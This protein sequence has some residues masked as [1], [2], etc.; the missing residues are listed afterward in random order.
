MIF[1]QRVGLGM[2]ILWLGLF[3]DYVGGKEVFFREFKYHNEG[4]AI[5]LVVGLT[6]LIADSKES[7]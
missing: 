6:L 4:L 3:M 5:L 2:C 7:V 1:R